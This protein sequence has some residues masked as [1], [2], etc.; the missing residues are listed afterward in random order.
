MGKKAILEISES[1]G[2]LKEIKS[3]QKSLKAERRIAA[4][5]HIRENKFETREALA[6]SLG[7]HIRTLERWVNRYKEDSIEGLLS[8]KPRNKPSKIITSEIHE[9]L[10]SRSSDP[11]NPF[12]GYWEA[13][14]WV[15]EEFG[16]DI[17]YHW[18]RAYMIKHFGTK[19][20]SPRKSH[21]KKDSEAGEA[22]LK[23]ALTVK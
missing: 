14:Q 9:G 15:L 6:E 5:I 19:V 22:F 17:N 13:R 7:V 2:D 11:S 20:K 18:L 8:D 23:T 12:L 10:A 1:L 16:A 4:L 3:K 21:V